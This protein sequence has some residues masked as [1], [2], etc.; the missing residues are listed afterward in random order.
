MRG[1]GWRIG[2]GDVVCRGSVNLEAELD[3]DDVLAIPIIHWCCQ[4]TLG[5]PGSKRAKEQLTGDKHLVQLVFDT[6]YPAY[7][8]HHPAGIVIE[9]KE[10]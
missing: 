2:L 8:L 9:H 1:S 10:L 4:R 6:R 5:V 7:D 3:R